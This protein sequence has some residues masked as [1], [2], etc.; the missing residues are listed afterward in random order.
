MRRGKCIT[1]PIFDD[2]TTDEYDRLSGAQEGSFQPIVD[3]SL[4]AEFVPSGM[5]A[6]N[7]W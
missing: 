3:L 5:R 6:D 1:E 7:V 4:L 2:Q